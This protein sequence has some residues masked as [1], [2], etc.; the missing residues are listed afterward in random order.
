MTII[1]GLARHETQ[2][3]MFSV[4]FAAAALSWRFVEQPFRVG[5]AIHLSRRGVFRVAAAS[6]MAVVIEASLAL[7]WRGFPNRF[8][9]E[10]QR[11]A[12]YMEA[13][14]AGEQFRTGRCFMI[15]RDWRFDQFDM[16]ECMREDGKKPTLLI[17]G[18]SH[19]AHL[20]WGMNI[21]FRDMNVMQ[22]TSAGCKPV[23]EQRPR[24]FP[25]CTRLMDYVLKEYLLS[26]RVDTLLLEA[27]WDDGDVPSL[28]RTLDW[29]RSKQVHVVLAG[30]MLQYDAPFP[31]L[32]AMSMRQRDPS[33][34]LL[35]RVGA[36]SVLDGEMADLARGEGHV[37]YIS[38]IDLLCDGDRGLQYVGGQVPLLSDYGHLTEE[39]SVLVAAKLRDLG[40]FP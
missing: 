30:P 17:L 33:L 15:G 7:F 10:A 13:G 5:G 2:A 27:R 40:R 36:M 28:S 29:L 20:W 24:Q 16:H 23:L 38:I 9:A 12:S 4:A 22:A 26:H 37:P 32:L 11:V 14:H 25:G 6:L 19:A 35:H 21:V 31:R 34:P 18:D 39:G 1:N 3:L 8:S